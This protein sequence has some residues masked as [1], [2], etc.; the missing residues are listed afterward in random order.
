MAKLLLIKNIDSKHL[1]EFITDGIIQLSSFSRCRI[2]EGHARDPLEG[3]KGFRYSSGNFESF[4]GKE[5]ERLAPEITCKDTQ[6]IKLLSVSNSIPDAYLFCTS[7][8]ILPSY[9]AHYY[10]QNTLMFG[11]LVFESLRAIDSG[12]FF[13]SLNKVIYGGLKD[14]I[15]NRKELELIQGKELKATKI[16]DY[17]YKPSTFSPDEEYRFVYFTNSKT[18]SDST[19]IRNKALLK[20][21]K[22][23]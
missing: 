5:L 20:Y 8:R 4:E 12:V 18:I 6:T 15:T 9:N 21:C 23:D 22:F 10:I 14:L 1:T 17:F 3:I 16:D 7:L 2:L 11:K 19:I 13:W